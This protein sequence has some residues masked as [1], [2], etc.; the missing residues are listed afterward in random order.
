MIMNRGVATKCLIMFSG[1]LMLIGGLVAVRPVPVATAAPPGPAALRYTNAVSDSFSDTFA[2]PSIIQAKNGWWYAYATADPLKAGDQPGLIH[3]A[4]TKDFVHWQYRG[5]VF[6]DRTRPSYA[7][8]SAGLWAP[9]IRYIDGRYVLYFAVT[10]TTLNADGADNAIGVATAPN[11]DGPWT[12]TDAPI[13]KPRLASGGYFLGTIDPAGFTDVD[14]RNY[15]YFGGFNGGIWVA[16]VSADGLTADTNYTQITI[17]NRYEGGYVIRHGGWYY[18][19]GSVANC[20]AGPT[21]GYSVYAGRSRSPLGPFVDQ[22]G[23]SLLDPYVGGTN[24]IM[25]NG[26]TYIGPGHNAIAT[27][28][29]GRTWIVYHA[30]DRNNPWLTDPFGVNRRPMLIDRI[31]W[32]DGWPRTRAGAGPSDTSQAAPVTTSGL[33]IAADDPAAH[34]VRGLSA[35]PIDDQA[36]RTARLDGIATTVAKASSGSVRVRFDLKA[37]GHPVTVTV[38]DQGDGLRVTVDPTAEQLQVITTSHGRTRTGADTI[39]GWDSGW[40]TLTVQVDHARIQ[41]SL[42]ESDLADP[43]AEVRLG[44]V[45]LPAA[46]VRF[47]G[48]GAELD[49]LTIRPV[50][51]EATRLVATPKAGKLLADEEFS[52]SDLTGWTWIRPDSA[53]S[54]SKGQFDFPVQAG[55]LSG[56]D[57]DASVLLHDPPT[58]PGDWMVETKLDLDL[59]TDEVRNYQQAGLV[60]Y[61]NDNDFARLDKVAIWNTRQVEFGRQ[62]VATDDGQTSWGG[63]IQ[64]RPARGSTWLRLAYHR[65]ADGEQQFRAAVSRDGR[66]WTWGGVWTFSAGEVPR[67]GLVAQ[68]GSSPALDAKFDYVRFH[69]VN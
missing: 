48:H 67:I 60:A 11:P 26:N 59:G 61:R 39:V 66:N 17:D 8:G 15:L 23:Q 68:G 7:T 34:G 10:D 24:V 19:M 4:R 25:Q 57:A 31:D 55:D 47:S 38:G 14:G 51:R 20:C 22:D 29:Q 64:A 27:D 2:D 46:P 42:G 16:K 63:S 18:F 58:T 6:T 44:G 35:G 12:A 30:I 54:V 41:A 9:D 53:A 36:G 1:L 21:T 40:H 69:A 5:T 33:G 65:T 45:R 49:N 13:I 28:A 37:T 32:I 50:A 56:D 43:G 3:I 62:L 52:D